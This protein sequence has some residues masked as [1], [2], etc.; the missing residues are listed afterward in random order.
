MILYY[1]PTKCYKT[2]KMLRR[3][4]FMRLVENKDKAYHYTGKIYNADSLNL[5]IMKE[6]PFI[7]LKL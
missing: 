2:P 6:G 4:L 7:V 3:N 5:F 1:T